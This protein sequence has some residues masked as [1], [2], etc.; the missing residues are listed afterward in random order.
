MSITNREPITVRLIPVQAVW[1]PL[2]RGLGKW[3]YGQQQKESLEEGQGKVIEGAREKCCG[4]VME[5]RREIGCA[6]AV[7][8]ELLFGCVLCST[9]R[10]SVCMYR[11]SL[12]FSQVII[13]DEC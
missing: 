6:I 7:T 5:R 8:E 1:W 4:Q 10:S 13:C 9:L 2:G 11:W 12:I 3:C